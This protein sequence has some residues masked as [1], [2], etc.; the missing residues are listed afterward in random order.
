[1]PSPPLN[2][3]LPRTAL[4]WLD[5]EAARRGV[6]RSELARRLLLEAAPARIRHD[7]VQRPSSRRKAAG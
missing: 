4:D 1:M 5:A 2:V 6:T 3:R 7:D